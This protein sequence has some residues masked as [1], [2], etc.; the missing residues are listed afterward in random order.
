MTFPNISLSF[1]F[2]NFGPIEISGDFILFNNLCTSVVALAANVYHRDLKPKNK[3]A[4]E[5]SPH[6]SF[7][8]YGAQDVS[9]RVFLFS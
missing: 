4:N 7:E 2:L 8:G 1:G 3:L 5:N 6:Q 9:L